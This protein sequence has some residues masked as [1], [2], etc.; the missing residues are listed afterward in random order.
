[1]Q[2]AITPEE[3]AVAGSQGLIDVEEYG[4]KVKR[5]EELISIAL[6]GRDFINGRFFVPI[7]CGR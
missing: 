1:M 7:R 5:G 2:D 4:A 3:K 6:N